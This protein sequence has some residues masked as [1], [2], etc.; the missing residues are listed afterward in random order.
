MIQ[1]GAKRTEQ[2][3]YIGITDFDV[4]LLHSKESEFRAVV[5]VLVEELYEQI[6]AQPELHRII[7]QH[8]TVERLK[9]TQRWYFLSMASGVINEP[10][11]EKRL[12]IGKIHSRI[13]LTTNWY[14]GTYILYLDLAAAH[15]QRIMPEE[16]KPLIHSL[17]KMFNLDSQLVLEAYEGGEKGKIQEMVEKQKDVL[18]V[19]SAAIQDLA[20]MLVQLSGSSQAVSAA[21]E[22]TAAFQEQTHHNVEYL[23]QE[24]TAIHH[25]GAVMR[26]V[27]D[28]T[29]LLG[30]NAAIEAARAGD[31]GRGFQVIAEE[32]RKLASRTKDS[33]NTIEDKLDRIQASL[34]AVRDNSEQSSAHARTQAASSRELASLV[35]MIEKVTAQLKSL[36]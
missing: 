7:L 10:F 29:H 9:E 3:N 15:F 17:S 35:K 19:V 6:T 4:D 14:L 30:L 18:T 12:H 5:D 32:V 8:S 20:A 11:I 26:E 31:H 13:G 24:V 23:A 21:A 28:Q 1:L 16:W 36:Q 22:Q 25:I 34:S 27:A 2:I 33:L